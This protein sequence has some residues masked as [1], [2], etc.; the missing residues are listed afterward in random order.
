[1]KKFLETEDAVYFTDSKGNIYVEKGEARHI[2][3]IF[4]EHLYKL[5][6]F[7]GIPI[8]EIDGLRMHLVK[9]FENPLQ[10]SK[11]IVR[12]LKIKPKDRVLDTCM[13]LGYTAIAASKARK[14]LTVEFNEPVKRLAEWNPWSKRLFSRKI[15]IKIGDV[16]EEIKQ[17]K[18]KSFSVI[19]HDPPRFSKAPQLYSIKFYQELY[20]VARPGARIYH[21]VGSVGR[22]KGRKIAEEVE[23][24]LKKTGFTDMDY[25]MKLQGLVFRKPA[26]PP[27]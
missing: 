15:E 6:L 9:D 14:V 10:Y 24:R 19:I 16:A 5:R 26:K 12:K 23:K 2:L 11:A 22:G 20:R 7:K 4:D 3:S 13:G 21:Y 18:D 1:M 25:D 8:L 27:R 17:M